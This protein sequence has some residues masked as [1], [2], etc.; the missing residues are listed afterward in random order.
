MSVRST[1]SPELARAGEHAEIR[2]GLRLHFRRRAR[3]R[4][5]HLFV[6]TRAL[7]V[8][9]IFAQVDNRARPSTRSRARRTK[10]RSRGA[11]F[12]GD[13]RVAFGQSTPPVAHGGSASVGDASALNVNLARRHRCASCASSVRA[14]K[15]PRRGGCR[16]ASRASS[17][18]SLVASAASVP[19]RPGAN[20]TRG[21]DG[22]RVCARRASLAKRRV[23]NGAHGDL[24]RGLRKRGGD[25]ARDLD[26][27]R[28]VVAHDELARRAAPTL[29]R[30][31]APCADRARGARG[32][33]ARFRSRVAARCPACP[34][35]PR[36]DPCE[37]ARTR[38]RP[39]RTRA[40]PRAAREV[41][42]RANRCRRFP[43]RTNGASRRDPPRASR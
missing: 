40:R 11:S 12:I 18:L 2:V 43:L 25:R 42:A 17:G 33:R 37:G 32:A 7:R 30:L 24:V 29:I 39:R 31:D 5:R 10:S 3:A 15:S 4:G 8:A 38:R 16:T 1:S 26:E 28:R 23:R 35:S 36:R 22:E 34:T 21:V 27:V 20:G 41:R 6:E 13:P 19:R 14:G 9:T